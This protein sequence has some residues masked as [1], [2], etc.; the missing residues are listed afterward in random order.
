MSVVSPAPEAPAFDASFV[1]AQFPAF[2]EP[3]LDGF[4]HLENAGG[5]YAC[6]PAIERLDHF[7]RE[8]KL[9]PYYPSRPSTAGGEAM[10]EART[11]WAAWLGVDENELHFGPS[12]TQNTYVLAQALRGWLQPG[13][14][15]VVTNQDHEANVGAFTRLAEAGFTVREWCVNPDTAELETADL[16]ALI[17]ERTRAVAFTHCSNIV[18]SINPVSEWCDLVRSV[19]ALSIVDGVSAAPHGTPWI[20]DLGADAYLFSMYKVYGPHLGLMTLRSEWCER[21]PNQGHYFN[22][23][24]PTARFTPAGPDHAQIA[25]AA[26]VLDYFEALDRH[27]A[28]G[29]TPEGAPGRVHDLLRAR[30]TA[31]VTP[32]LSFL[33]DHPRVR[34]IGRTDSKGRAPTVA[35]TVEGADPRIL[36]EALAGKD[37]GT[38]YGDFYARR[39]VEALGIDADSGVLRCSLV[40]YNTPDDVARLEHA[41]ETLLRN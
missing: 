8:T 13:D 3:S 31:L 26:G 36:C 12:T 1:H 41:L 20:P 5:S 39:L 6:A 9:Q 27:H 35:F 34:L 19:G 33:G 24:K 2:S 30:E 7:Y 40:H 14:E 10:D 23:G 22:A 29:A 37:I 11:R 38:G 4:V 16:E 15:V 17:N 21:L 32:L 18:G 25:A 28:P